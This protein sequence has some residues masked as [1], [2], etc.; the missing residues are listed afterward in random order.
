M[1]TGLL[2]FVS[3]L[4]LLVLF[5]IAYYGDRR[6]GLTGKPL[7]GPWVYSLS[8][9][10]YCTSWTFFGS[11]G[12]ASQRGLM[13]LPIYLGPTL[14]A[15]L[16][17]MVV[18]KMVRIGRA[19]RIT[20]IADFISS[21]YGKSHSVGALVTVIAIIGIVPYISLQ[22]KAVW[23]AISTHPSIIAAWSAPSPSNPSSS[24]PRSCWWVG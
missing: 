1:S 3:L 12:L 16:W 18:G 23:R 21:R 5:A 9:A 20:S 17:P 11:V 8:L 7:S 15:A 6:V 4:Y 10:V 13:F 2:A 22:L 19:E 24:W 14:M